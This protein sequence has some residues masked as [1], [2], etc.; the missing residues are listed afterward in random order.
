MLECH[1]TIFL[2]LLLILYA[3]VKVS[4]SA[5]AVLK[6]N[7]RLEFS[8]THHENTYISHPR[9]FLAIASSF[10]RA[11]EYFQMSQP[12]ASG[13][14]EAMPSP[15]LH[16][17]PELASCLAHASLKMF[18][19]SLAHLPACMNAFC[20]ALTSVMPTPSRVRIVPNK[21]FGLL[22]VFSKWLRSDAMHFSFKL[23]MGIDV[24][25]GIVHA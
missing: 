13:T 5:R 4:C 14:W 15:F 16:D 11:V 12:L 17:G 25:I 22:W 10:S 23:C 3:A 8:P 19:S 20:A 7:G 1:P 24:E 18:P 2:M 21:V 6:R 9:N